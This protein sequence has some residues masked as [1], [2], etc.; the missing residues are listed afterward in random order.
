MHEIP[1]W[2]KDRV[3][4]LSRHNAIPCAAFDAFAR[5]IAA[6]EEPPVDPLLA[7][8]KKIVDRHEYTFDGLRAAVDEALRRGMELAKV[9]S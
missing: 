7:E 8:R 3:R 6:H 9:Q 2:A 5:Y 1:E 4:E